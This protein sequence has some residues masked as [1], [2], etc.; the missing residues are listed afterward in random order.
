M[1]TVSPLIN[2][3]RDDHRSLSTSA[4]NFAD[5]APE[6]LPDFSAVGDDGS[7]L[8]LLEGM[9][10]FDDFFIVIGDGDVLPDLEILGDYSGGGRDEA[11]AN[12]SPEPGEKEG[13]A[14]GDGDGVG[15]PGVSYNGGGGT[16]KTVRRG[17]NSKHKGKNKDGN[18]SDK[19]SQ[20]K[21]KPKVDWTAELHRKFVEAVEQLGVEKAVPSRIL[22][23]MNVPSLTRHNVASHLQKYRSHRKHL[24]ARE[25]EAAKWNLRRQATGVKK[26][27]TAP[28][29]GF[30]HVP[31]VPFHVWGHPTACPKPKPPLAA[32]PPPSWPSP[33]PSFWPHQ[34]IYPHGYGVAS[35]THSIY[36]SD[37]SIGVPTAPLNP[38]Q[39]PHPPFHFHP[40]NESIDAA[41]GDVISKPWSPLPLGLKPPSL[42]GVM[43]ELQRQGIS[44]MPPLP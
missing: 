18:K 33:N 22:E 38:P 19:D 27:W 25:A 24:M 29:L 11:E 34:P 40:S 4:A 43:T 37:T 28:A 41:I 26:P 5:L 1:L 42:D 7:S 6:D 3:E 2:T 30:P 15:K 21:K 39:C 20:V 16:V 23:I 31:H 12:T 17:K 13:D 44:N 10:Y 32:A 36:K 9:D 14:D 35:S 8:S